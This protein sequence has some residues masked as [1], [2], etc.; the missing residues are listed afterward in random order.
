[1]IDYRLTYDNASGDTYTILENNILATSYT[2]M[3]LTPGITYKFKLQARNSFGLSAY[4]G[5]L[6]LQI[7]FMPDKPYAPATTVL[8]DEVIV[9]WIAPN[10]NG[11]I[12]SSYRI[13]LCQEDEVFMEETT[14]CDGS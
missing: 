12:I 10:E 7:G 2:V 3:D 6:E 1:M 8:N 11:A 13:T 9:S 14:Y 4:T 5:E